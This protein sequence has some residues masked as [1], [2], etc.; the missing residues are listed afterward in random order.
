MRVGS[1][2]KNIQNVKKTE[3]IKPKLALETAFKKSRS[4]LKVYTEKYGTGSKIEK[5][6]NVV[7]HYEGWL[8]EDFT[9]FDSSKQKR[10][11]FEFTLGEGQVIPGWEEALDGVRAGS[12]LQLKIPANLAYGASGNSGAGIPANADLIFKVQVVRVK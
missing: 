8:A 7:V 6:K 2:G 9:L 3:N 4:G 12:V 11:P 1:A 10:R 5:G